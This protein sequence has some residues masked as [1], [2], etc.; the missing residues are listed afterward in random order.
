MITPPVIVLPG[1][2]ASDLYD[3]YELPPEALWTTVLK[4]G[5]ERITLHPENQRYELLEPARVAPGGPFPLAYE[6]LIEELRDGLA[7]D[8]PG[9]VPVFPFG[10]DWRMPL[11]RIEDQLA[12]FVQEVIERALLTKHYRA[13]NAFRENPCVSLIGHSMG[14]LVIAGYVARHTG[15]YIDKVVTLGTPF[16]GSYEAI[17][18]VTTGTSEIGDQSGKARE[19]RMARMTPALYHLLPAT[20]GQVAGGGGSNV[21]FFSPKAWQPS[22]VRAIEKQV[23]GWDVSGS[24]LFAEMLTMAKSHRDVISQLQLSD[25]DGD[26]PREAITDAEWLA[27][28]GVDSR[29][30]VGLRVVHDDDEAPRFDFRSMERR[31]DWDSEDSADRYATGDGT[32]HLRG[33]VPPF[34]DE[35]RIVCVAPGDFGYWEVR[36]RTLAK[37]VN[38]HGFL[39]TMNMVHRLIVRFLLDRAD[40]YGNTWGRRLPGVAQWRPPLRLR[41]K[42]GVLRS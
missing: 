24:E 13:D 28:V 18:K 36:D 30:R 21:N 41:E 7:E 31:N 14:G 17:L 20:Q 40:R 3:E 27:V 23:D 16:Q 5:Y 15:R 35:S 10:Y 19:R 34:L 32:V 39:P 42:V 8:Q 12:A 38:F 4:R 22:V 1:I 9:P 11:R 2:T 25:G 29:T 33:A 26:P 6:D 37:A